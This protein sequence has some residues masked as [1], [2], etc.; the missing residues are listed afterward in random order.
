MIVAIVQF[1]LPS[2]MTLAD[3]TDTIFA[4]SVD[5]YRTMPGLIRKNY[6]FGHGK[7]GGVYLWDS[8][9][10]A[11]RAYSTEWRTM[12]AD[13]FGAEPTVTYFESPI[14][15]ENAEPPRH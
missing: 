14:E 8:S 6:L 9:E 13:R 10:S 5:K 12:M 15:V 1:N 11:D 4:P 2:G 7:G 3:A